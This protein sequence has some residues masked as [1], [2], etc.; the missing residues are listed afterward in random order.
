MFELYL[1]D[2]ANYKFLMHEICFT[3]FAIV[4]HNCQSQN[5]EE[6]GGKMMQINS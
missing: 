4:A 1:N 3:V 6:R 2:F 5:C